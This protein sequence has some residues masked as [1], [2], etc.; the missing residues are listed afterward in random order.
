[1]KDL[2]LLDAVESR[3]PIG[4]LVLGSQATRVGSNTLCYTAIINTSR[5]L[6]VFCNRSVCVVIYFEL[7]LQQSS[8]E[9]N[10]DTETAMYIVLVYIIQ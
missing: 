5:T 3:A 10:C 8:N 7:N 2:G 1:M 6:S 4:L 9:L